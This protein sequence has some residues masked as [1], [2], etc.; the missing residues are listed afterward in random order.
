VVSGSQ[1]GAVGGRSLG[2]AGASPKGL[3][4]GSSGGVGGVGLAGVIVWVVFGGDVG[5]DGCAS[6]F[7]VAS[8]EGCDCGVLDV[9]AT[10]FSG[11]IGVSCGGGCGEFVVVVW[12]GCAQVMCS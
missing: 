5:W 6:G 10:G 7:W 4:E 9:F 1:E 2:S 11:W 8:S 12:S 3:S